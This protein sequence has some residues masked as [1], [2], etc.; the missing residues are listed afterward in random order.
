[1]T[2]SRHLSLFHLEWWFLTR[3]C[4]EGCHILSYHSPHG[5]WF[6]DVILRGCLV[7]EDSCYIHMWRG[8]DHLGIDRITFVMSHWIMFFTRW[9]CHVFSLG[10]SFFFL[11]LDTSFHFAITYWILR[12]MFIHHDHL[13]FALYTYHEPDT[14]FFVWSLIQFSTRC[15]YF[16]YGKVKGAF[17]HPHFFREIRLDHP[18]IFSLMELGLKVE[19]KIYVYRWSTDLVIVC[20]SH[21]FY[22]GLLTEIL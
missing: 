8:F 14:S 6:R 10:L 20:F 1:M 5:Q 9:V 2:W 17:S 11:W 18:I 22:L 12:D 15:S 19:L 4:M 13:D 21:L 7:G 16:H 3:H